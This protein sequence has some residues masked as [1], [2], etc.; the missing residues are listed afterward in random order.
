MAKITKEDIY[1]NTVSTPNLNYITEAISL[2]N[3]KQKD[4]IKL[5]RVECSR[6]GA[7]K[8]EGYVCDYCK[9]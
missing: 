9:Q 6:C 4:S 3:K 5:K 8:Y 1:D 2:L 7:S